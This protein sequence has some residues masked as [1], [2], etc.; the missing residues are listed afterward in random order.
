MFVDL[1]GDADHANE[2][3]S[4]WKVNMKIVRKLCMRDLRG[5]ENQPIARFWLFSDYRLVV[6]GMAVRDAEM[7]FRT[8]QSDGTWSGSDPECRPLNVGKDIAF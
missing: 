2:V 1:A 7:Y 6:A 8:C 3:P 5:Y 4:D